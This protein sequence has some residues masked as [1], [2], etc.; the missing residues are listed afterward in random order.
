MLE[1]DN[2]CAAIAYLQQLG[3]KRTTHT[4]TVKI[5]RN[6]RKQFPPRQQESPARMLR[7]SKW[8]PQ[9]HSPS[10]K[11]QPQKVCYTQTESEIALVWLQG[12]VQAKQPPQKKKRKRQNK[13]PAEQTNAGHEET[14]QT[15]PNQPSPHQPSTIPQPTVFPPPPITFVWGNGAWLRGF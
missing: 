6:Q 4:H 14:S 2:C 13:K 3:L 1:K 8:L 15:F 5:C 9:H 7:E 11:R 12:Q 10:P